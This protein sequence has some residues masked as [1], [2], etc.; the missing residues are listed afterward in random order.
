MPIISFYLVFIEHRC[1]NKYCIFIDNFLYLNDAYD[2]RGNFNTD[3]ASRNFEHVFQIEYDYVNAGHLLE[4]HTTDSDRQ[5]PSVHV[6]F[7]NFAC[8]MTVFLFF[9]YKFLYKK[10]N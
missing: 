1:H 2:C 7:Q 8:R 3:V 10:F 6:F 4:K 9:F 5:R